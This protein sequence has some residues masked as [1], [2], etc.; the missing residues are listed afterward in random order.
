[1][2]CS[3]CYI[4]KEMWLGLDN[5]YYLTQAKNYTLRITMVSQDNETAVSQY[6]HFKLTN[7]VPFLLF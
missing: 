4:G 6:D 1:M 7:K 3:R 2:F 5:M